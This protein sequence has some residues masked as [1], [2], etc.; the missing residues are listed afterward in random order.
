MKLRLHG[1]LTRRRSHDQHTQ[2]IK[3]KRRPGSGAPLSNR[4]CA[5]RR[6][7]GCSRL[8]APSTLIRPV[9]PAGRPHEAPQH[10]RVRSE[11]LARIGGGTSPITVNIQCPPEGRIGTGPSP[12]ASHKQPAIAVVSYP[13]APSEPAIRVSH[14]SHC[15]ASGAEAVVELYELQRHQLRVPPPRLHQLLPPPPLSPIRPPPRHP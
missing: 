8:T 12:T 11:F 14:P 9:G 1:Q 13:S 10:V 3:F 2:T 6:H 7:P 5:E 15:R 4:G